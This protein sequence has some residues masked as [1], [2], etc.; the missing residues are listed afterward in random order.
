MAGPPDTERFALFGPKVTLAE[1]EE[2]GTVDL[3]AL[4]R[5]LQRI[6]GL[7]AHHRKRLALALGA[8]LGATIFTL[9]IPHLL[10]G[11]VDQ[12]SSL[13][14]AGGTNALRQAK[15]SLWLAAGLLTAAAAARGLLTMMSG[16]HCEWL[17]QRIAYELRL[18][19]F[20]KL[21][22]LEFDYHDRMHSGDLI[23]RGMLD[24]EG[25]RM[26]LENGLQKTL[27]LTL[28]VILGATMM[29]R[30][31]PLLAALAFS[32][33]PFV[34]WR[35]VRTGLFLRLTWTR[36]QQRMSV[37]T[38]TI[39]ENL[40]GMRVVR[41]FAAKDFEIGKFDQDA[42]Q[43]LRMSNHRILIR[44]SAVSSMTFSFYL[45]MALILWIGGHRVI[46]GRISVGHLAEF[47]TFMTLLQ[48]PVRQIMII[49]NTAARAVASGSRLFDILDRDSA[50]TDRPGARDLAVSGGVLRFENVSFSYG[51]DHS[52]PIL[53]NIN[54]EVSAG[55]TLGIV[56]APGSGKTSLAHLIPRFYDVS[57]GRITIDGQDIRGVRLASLRAAISLVPQ[58]VFLFDT[59]VADNILYAA[60]DLDD[61][62]LIAA[63]QTAHIHDY[64]SGLPDLYKTHVGERGGGLSGGQRQRMSIARGIVPR[65]S[66]LI[67]DDATSAIDAATEQRVRA[68][69]RRS[70]DS[71]AVIIISHRLSALM[72]A[73]EILVLDSGRIIER[74]NH[75]SLLAKGGR[76]AA[77]FHMQSSAAHLAQPAQKLENAL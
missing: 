34:A 69:L 44:T 5:V 59:T 49:V 68:A 60:P 37:L 57:Q 32:F 36:L 52:K 13:V 18:A 35:A 70:T 66:F 20:D 30:S 22:L 19:F 39:E 74:G 16:Y 53:Q 50:I 40:Q 41:A 33:V 61:Q 65:P 46:S 1:L 54:F 26:F 15:Q 43:A 47:L 23:T 17:G 4:P 73:D 21:Q 71:Q 10:G 24:L 72:H 38:R 25:V 63:A 7:A 76:Y 11:A 45:A 64:V 14:L 31:D 67:F 3:R 9:A 62:H 77:L 6:L 56:G 2:S 55:M 48:T 42:T 12:A 29:F 8:T 27:T 75:A 28:L 51:K 58:D